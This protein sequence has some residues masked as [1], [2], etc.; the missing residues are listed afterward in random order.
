MAIDAV[1]TNALAA[2]VPAAPAAAGAAHPASPSP[3]TPG[4]A[5]GS[6]NAAQASGKPQDAQN[7]SAPAGDPAMDGG[8]FH[9]LLAGLVQKPA[10]PDGADDGA[11]GNAT[12]KKIAAAEPDVDPAAALAALNAAAALAA[13][14]AVRPTQPAATAPAAADVKSAKAADSRL[15]APDTAATD[16]GKPEAPAAKPADDKPDAFTAVLDAARHESATS[17]KDTPQAAA[18]ISSSAAAAAQALAAAQN[19]AP[20]APAPAAPEVTATVGTP[21]WQEQVGDTVTW[22]AKA[23]VHSAEI[24]VTPPDMGPIQ[25]QVTLEGEKRDQA[26][27]QFVAPHPDTRDALENALPRLREMLAGAG[28]NLAGSTVGQQAQDSGQFSGQSQGTSGHGGSISGSLPGAAVSSIAAR[29]D[30]RGLVD[31]FV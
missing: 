21:K 24:K 25:I 5:S 15:Q 14:V 28:I 16:K 18:G 4:S 10:S 31:T 2:I 7:G 19:T 30:S 26:I 13:P 27:V 11:D 3:Q 23:D 20:A 29:G 6:D 12:H 9:K 1:P 8:S 17:G 22:M